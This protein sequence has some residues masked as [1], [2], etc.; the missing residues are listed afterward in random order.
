MKNVLFIMRLLK[1]QPN[2]ELKVTDF[3]P[4][5]AKRAQLPGAKYYSCKKLLQHPCA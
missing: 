5:R 1:G 2:W 4:L 3:T